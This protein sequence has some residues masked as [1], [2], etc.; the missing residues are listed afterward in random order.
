M[1]THTYRADGT[2]TH[3][4]AEEIIQT[5]FHVELVENGVYIMRG[6]VTATNGKSDCT[7]SPTAVGS[8]FESVI[9]F[10]KDGNFYSCPTL[11]TIS[12]NGSELRLR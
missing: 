1:E 5:L 12:C 2:G 10:T 4:S 7:G 11:E 8:R 3:R 6:V 9:R